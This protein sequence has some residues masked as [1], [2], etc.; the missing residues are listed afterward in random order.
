MIH[1]TGYFLLC[2]LLSF[3]TATSAH[4]NTYPDNRNGLQAIKSPKNRHS[5]TADVTASSQQAEQRLLDI[6]HLIASG[7]SSDAVAQAASLARE[8]PNFQLAQLVYGDLLAAK[9][10]NLHSWGDIPVEW[11]PKIG[12]T[13]DELRAE[14][15]Q[16]VLAVNDLPPPGSIPSQFLQIPLETRHAIAVDASRSRLYL[17]ENRPEG[18]VLM[19]NFYISV[20]K[21]GIAKSTQGDKRTPLG[22]YFITNF[23]DAASLKNFYGSGALPINYPNVLDLM[24]GKTGGGIWLHGTPPSQFSQ[25]PQASN[26]CIVMAN[27]D[28]TYLLQHIEV[29]S[30]PVLISPQITWVDPSETASESKQFDVTLQAWHDAKESG[31]LDAV[32]SFYMSNVHGIGK[33]LKNWQQMLQREI[34]GRQGKD[35]ALKDVSL[36]HWTDSADTMVVTFVEDFSGMDVGMKKRQFWMKDGNQWKIFFETAI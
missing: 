17:F 11:S 33:S 24:R 6:Y 19:A 14:F 22:I 30:T 35:L 34:S 29:G 3:A 23:L 25:A 1:L 4:S 28:L 7:Y 18:L 27:P 16:R 2:L 36:L 26:G 13:L 20:G 5:S 8:Y 12:H 9:I 21:A 31:R 15:H 32:M 10:R